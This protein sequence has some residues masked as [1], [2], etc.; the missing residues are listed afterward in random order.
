MAAG[1]VRSGDSA[2]QLKVNYAEAD[3]SIFRGNILERTLSI[4]GKEG[5]AIPAD[6]MEFLRQ[7]A[8]AD[9]GIPAPA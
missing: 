7:Q 5:A 1:R 6:Q 3:L 8:D 4:L 9:R 2:H